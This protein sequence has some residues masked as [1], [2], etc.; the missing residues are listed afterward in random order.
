LDA[1]PGEACRRRHR[2]PRRRDPPGFG[3][4]M[5]RVLMVGVRVTAEASAG[6]RRAPPPSS[7]SGRAPEWPRP[8][9]LVRSCPKDT[10]L[11]PGWAG[12]C[13][14]RGGLW[15]ISSVSLPEGLGRLEAGQAIIRAKVLFLPRAVERR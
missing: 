5:T 14:R 11:P 3:H 12:A 13:P 10:A 9:R 7:A 8:H 4:R 6:R 2:S 1:A 15:A